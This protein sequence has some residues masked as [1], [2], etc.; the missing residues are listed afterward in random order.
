MKQITLDDT[1]Q[2]LKEGVD[3]LADVVKVTLGGKG[4]NVIINNGFENVKIINDGVTIAREV[5][6]EDEVENT[7]AMLAKQ[8]A[9]KTN[10]EAGDATTTT[11][12]LLQ[13]FMNEMMKIQS[14]DVRGLREEIDNAI[15]NVIKYLDENKKELTEGDI[16]RIAKNSSLDEDIAKTV[17]EIMKK[18]GKDGLV[19]IEDGRFPGIDSEVVL[20]IKIDDGYLS[21][22]MI[23]DAETMKSTLKENVPILITKKRITNMKEILPLVENL[24][25]QGKNEMLVLVEDI[26]DDVLALMVVNKIKGNFNFCVVRTRNMDDIAVVTGAQIVTEEAGGQFTAEMLG[27][28]DK[29]ETG[30]YFCQIT[31]GKEDQKTVDAKIEEL[32]KVRE[33]SDNEY[34]AQVA[35]TRIARLQGGVSIIRIAGTNEQQTKEKK[36]KLDDALNAV[37]SAMD[38]GIIEGG[39]MALFRASKNMEEDKATDSKEKIEAKFLVQKVIMTPFEQIIKNADEN[40]EEVI[41]EPRNKET[42]YNVITRQ[43]ENFYESGIIDPVKAVKRALI[44]AFAMGTSI[45]TAEA[46][47]IVKKEN[48]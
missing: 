13:A 37:K 48:K 23:T 46:G 8:A 15:N 31:G 1:R 35:A 14:K 43:W 26:P 21:P 25:S 42:G 34:D 4:K 33:N 7:G 47:I 5:E 12:V 11:I 29:V 19:S 38:E 45:M 9:E 24:Q 27:Y 18:I 28:A 32:K 6:L 17:E 20:G 10:D 22:Y 3:M 16:F 2:K 36:L 41:R 30:K 44:N 40:I 39:G